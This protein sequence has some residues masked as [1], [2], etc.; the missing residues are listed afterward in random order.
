M[1]PQLV[2][3]SFYCFS[4]AA[5]CNLPFADKVVSQ[6]GVKLKM[7]INEYLNKIGAD[8]IP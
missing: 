8:K 6:I 7:V 5:I 3:Q 1:H 2:A 4:L